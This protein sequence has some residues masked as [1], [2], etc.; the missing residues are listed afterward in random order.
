MATMHAMQVQTPGTITSVELPVPEP[1][2]GEVRV[3]VEA[4]GICHSD[5]F[6][7]TAGW[8]GIALPRSPGHEIAGV[9][10]AIGEGVTTT[11]PG[12]RVG[13]GWHGGHDGTCTSCR[14]G[15]F[16]ACTDLRVPGITYDGGYAPYVIAAAAV[17]AAIPDELSFTEAAPLL[18]AG[19]TTYNALRH[20]PAHG[21]DVVAVLGV[22]GLGHLGVQFAAKMGFAT[23][24]IAR[25][26]DKEALARSLGAI[27]YID[28]ESEDVAA[29]L[30]ARGG[31]RVVLATATSARAMAQTIGGLGV[32][33]QLLVL[34]AP[35]DALEVPAAS[36]IGGR[37]SIKGWPSGIAADSED[38]MRFSVLAG[39]RPMV[40]TMP[41][42]RAQEAYEK[43]LSGAARFRMV[44]NEYDT[45]RPR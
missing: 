13:I 41:L 11:Q 18:C 23:V 33:G 28:S 29:R 35:H 8:P 44:L 30:Q 10:D 26:R 19:L 22:G 14:R 31:A 1:G 45:A 16:V 2:P 17:L 40:E 24:A 38:T 6:T 7:V 15:D 9:V 5:M 12:A 39:I 4:C 25:G 34:G 37:R 32:D 20:S 3:R 21:G 42:A 43:M 36:L 27:D